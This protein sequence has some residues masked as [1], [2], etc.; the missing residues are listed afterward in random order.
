M[1]RLS[2]RAMAALS[3]CSRSA[4]RS[5]TS[6]RSRCGRSPATGPSSNAARAAAIAASVSAAVASSTTPTSVPSAGQRIS[7][8]PPSRALTQ[9]ASYVQRRRSGTRSSRSTGLLRI[10]QPECSCRNGCG[11]SM[12]PTVDYVKVVPGCDDAT[13]TIAF[14]LGLGC[15]KGGT[16]WLHDYLAASPQCDPGFRKEYHV[17]DGLDLPSEAWMRR[18]VV[19]RAAKAVDALERGDARQR[20]RAA[21][22][23]LLRRPRDV[24]RLLH[25]AAGPRRDPAHL[26]H[27][28]VVR[29]A[30]RRPARRRSGT[31]FAA[32]RRAHGAGVL[33][34]GPGR[35]DLVDGAD[36]PA[37]P[38]RASSRARPRT[39]WPGSSRA[40]TTRRGPATTS[41]W[42]RSTRRSRPGAA[43]GGLLRAALR[44]RRPRRPVRA[45]RH[46]PPRPR[47]RAT[48]STP[49]PRAT[50][51]PD[52][53]V[54]QVAGHYRGV[55]DAVAARFPDVDL[56]A[57]LA[58]QPLPVTVEADCCL[59]GSRQPPLST[60]DP[61]RA[62]ATP[63]PRRRS[64]GR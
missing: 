21:P 33:D 7:R 62:G 57:R 58:E 50:P 51:L 11:L 45:P 32:P 61:S 42:P 20:R 8:R 23:G 44:R 47:P 54:A 22:G 9:D 41:P 30:P 31:G 19:A 26:R 43:V 3:R 59:T 60:A 39:G 2:I 28:A 18:R 38:P 48:S 12:G 34:A 27:H 53:L 10:E 40:T 5:S 29:P 63:R 4:T 25:R 52:A 36:E 49:R 55:Y 24:L 13:M 1:S 14:A 15:Q 37:A 64:A 16:S 46:R 56:G 6:P 17:F 35:A